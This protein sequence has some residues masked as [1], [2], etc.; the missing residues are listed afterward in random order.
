MVS[1]INSLT[2]ME[3]MLYGGASGVN[4]NCPSFSNGYMANRNSWNYQMPY[5]YNNQSVW[6]N[7]FAQQ[8]Y[9]NSNVA[10]NAIFSS[11]HIPSI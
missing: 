9:G 1:P 8:G 3:Y 6:N 4:P 2:N 7:Q 11:M 5:G 10:G